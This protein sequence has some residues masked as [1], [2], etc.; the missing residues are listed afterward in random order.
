SRD[1][2]W[3]IIKTRLPES[4]RN[5]N[6]LLQILGEAQAR[7]GFDHS[8]E[9][10]VAICRITE[11]RPRLEAQGLVLEDRQRVFNGIVVS[12]AQKFLTAVVPDSALM[13]EQLANR[14]RRGFL[15]KRRHV[16]LHFIVEIDLTL[17]DQ[18]HNT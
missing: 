18:L 16:N 15:R 13:A 7:S 11:F 12:R 9:Q 14:N 3:L 5:K 4:E 8:A 17:L 6:V 10:H 1:D 2:P